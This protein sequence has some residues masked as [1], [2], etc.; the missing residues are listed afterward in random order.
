MVKPSLTHVGPL[1][2]G[3][4]SY[5]TPYTGGVRVALACLTCY[6]ADMIWV[7]KLVLQIVSQ[8]GTVGRL[9]EQLG[10]GARS[11]PLLKCRTG[12]VC[13]VP[14]LSGT[15]M[16][17]SECRTCLNSPSVAEHNVHSVGCDA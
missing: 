15:A 1:L 6:C 14:L 16:W 11:G 17:D 4:L 13:F 12:S 8:L 7:A 10:A 3:Y 9:Q 5:R 2:V